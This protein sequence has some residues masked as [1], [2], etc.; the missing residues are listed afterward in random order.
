MATKGKETK[1]AKTGKRVYLFEEGSSQMRPLLGGKGCELS[2]MT[3]IGMPVPPGFTITTEVCKE[4]L[5][6]GKMSKELEKDIFDALATIEEKTGKKFGD[7]GNPLLVS[8]RSGSSVSMPG[9][10]D[11]ILNLGLNEET[12]KGLEKHDE[13]FAWD[14]YR[15]FIQMFG[16]VVLEVPKPKFEKVFDS[17]KERYGRKTDTEV[18]PSELKEVVSEYKIL[19]KNDTGTPFP[20]DPKQQLLMATEAVF[21]SWNNPRAI[22]YRK[23][24][25]ISDELGTAV[26][27]VAMVFGNTGEDS[28]TGVAFTRSP[29]TGEKKLYG[30]FLTNAQGEDVVAGIRTPMPISEM[31]SKFPKIYG[32]FEEIAKKLEK[33]YRD[34]QDMEFTIEHGRLWMLQTRNGKRTAAA[35]VKAAVDMVKE[36]LISKEEAIMRVAPEQIDQM[37]HKQIDPKAKV[38]PIAKGLPASPGAAVGKLVFSADEAAELGKKE[39]VILCAVE[40]TPE[41]IHGMVASQGILTSRGGMT[42]HAAVVARG[43]G[44]PCIVGCEAAKIDTEKKIMTIN[45]RKFKQGDVVTIDGTTGNV[46]EGEV[47]TIEPKLT[48]EFEELLGW[49]DNASTMYVRANADTPYNA[50]SAR[51]FGAKGIGLCRTERMFNDPERLPIVQEMILSENPEARENALAKLMPL[52]KKD[53]REIL[54]AMD[55]LPVTIRLLDPPLH[56]FLPK[57]DE[58][59]FDSA[60]L[61]IEKTDQRLLEEKQHMLKKVRELSEFNPMLGHRGCRL[62]ITYPEIYEMQVQAIF[63]AACELKKAGKNPIVEVMIPLV[64]NVN[65]LRTLRKLV[66]RVADGTIKGSGTKFAYTVGTMIELPRACVT[67]DEIAQEADFFSFGTN[68]LTQ[69]TLGFSRDDAEAKFLQLYISDK[70]ID[71]NPFEVLD[72]NGVGKLVQMGVNLG[73]QTKKDLKIGV[74]GETGGEPS[75][76]EFYYN[77]GLN[78]VSCSRYRVPIARLAAAQATIRGRKEKVRVSSTV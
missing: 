10:M 64:G 60:K 63:E 11:T 39:K 19:I 17:V 65:E 70:I 75:S 23:I 67:A 1:S 15:R 34:M 49:C 2:E 58:L 52:Q 46:I 38:N 61:A 18:K 59:I 7:S 32:Q 44:L 43:M 72:R 6:A 66:T 42:A 53:F 9:M 57:L 73:R 5:K 27:V 35:A 50:K 29:S 4:Y 20:S 33:H 47:K 13:R 31:K 21:R 26:N 8:V 48:E 37:L 62:G 16:N 22:T 68:D 41:D 14:A 3:N 28:G 77:A 45:G 24:Y 69:T 74:C 71:S 40:T 55:G 36:G 51:D 78:Y 25:K 30:E 76:I 12:I 54:L 56:E